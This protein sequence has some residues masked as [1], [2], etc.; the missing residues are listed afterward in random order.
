MSFLANLRIRPKL[1]I[2]MTPL[3]VMVVAATLYSSIQSK[4]IDTWYSDL[5]NRDVKALQ[6]LTAV[7]ARG[8]LFGLLLYKD[9]AEADAERMHVIEADLDRAYANYQAQVAEAERQNPALSQEIKLVVSLFDQAVADARPVR[10]ASLAGDN[11]KAMNLMRGRVDAELDRARIAIFRLVDEAQLS[12][13]RKSDELSEKTHRTILTTWIAL[14]LGLLASSIL[15]IVIV[16]KEVVSELLALHGSIGDLAGGRL[17]GVIPYQ[18]HASEIGE[19]SRA[20][21]TLQGVARE[22]NT[23]AWVKAQVAATVESLQPAKDFLEFS[24]SLLSRL[25]DAI[26]LLYGVVYVADKDRTRFSPA[27]SFA[28]QGQPDPE[29]FAL[30]EGLVGQAAFE[31]RTLVVTANADNAPR[32]S[33][34]VGQAEPHTLLFVPVVNQKKAEAVLELAPVSPLSERQ[35]ALL[36]A[37]LSSV[38]ANLEI[39]SGNME[40][41]G[42]LEQ[43]RMQAET[44]AASERQL[45]ARK[46][47]LESSNAALA[48]SEAELRRAKEVAEEATQV[49]SD[50]LARMSHEIRTPMNAVIGMS[51]LALRTD[52]NPR[53][54]DY[55]RKIQQ[56][57]QHLLGLIND[58]L[59]FSKIEAGKLSVENIDFDLEKMLEN[60]SNLTS[61][62]AAA[63]GLELILDIDPAVSMH[64][65]GDPL[66]LGQILINFCNNAVK[67]TE[68]GEIV[69]RIRV[70]EQ[71]E[72]GQLIHFAVSDTGIGLTE[73]QMGRLFQ[74]FEQADA[75][76]TRQYGG[77]GLGLAISKRLAELMGGEIGVTS[78]PGKGSTFWFT[79]RLG[80]TEG[81]TRRSV[82]HPDLRGRRVLVIDD[83]SQ[84][85]AVLSDM[86]TAMTLVVHEAPS[87]Q[88]GI[89]MVRRAAEARQPY[90]IV[91]LDWQMPGLDGIETGKRIRGLPGPAAAPHL[92]MVTA[93]GR[94]EV[95]KQAE[96]SGFESVLIKPVS[97]SM[98]FDASIRA[99]SAESETRAGLAEAQAGPSPEAA[100]IR[101]ARVLLVEDNEINREV[102]LGLLDGAHL[103]I[104]IAENGVAAVRMVG[105][106]EYDVVLMDMQMPVMDG[107]T[108]SRKIRSDA[109][110]S[111][112]PIIAMTASALVSDREKC[113]QAG[114]ND[115]I[116]K[117]ID[118]GQ[119]FAVLAR[120][121]KPREQEAA[122]SPAPA[123][124]AAR[125]FADGSLPEIEGVDVLE[126]LRRVA[127]NQRL[128]RDLLAKFA[129][130]QADSASQI[131]AALKSGDPK[132]AE[133]IAHSMKGVAGNLGISAIQSAAEKLEAAIRGGDAGVPALLR[134]TASLLAVQ[135]KAIQR[136][137]PPAAPA[138]PDGPGKAAFD[139][140]A[141][142]AGVARLRALL[143]ASDGDAGEAFLAL[144]GALAGAV[145][146]PQVEALRDA[147]ADFDF[148]GGLRKLG[149]IAKL[150]G[151]TEGRA[152]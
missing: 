89:E 13:D 100:R 40:T 75:S 106:H 56:S 119:L 58:I 31:Q 66:R 125:E 12:V 3:G 14:G 102:A 61:E 92:V 5:L 99:L 131:S 110:F 123:T 145:A 62:K 137:L 59:D 16:Q 111:E 69:V 52:L 70:Q 136:A 49:K 105:E 82:S 112:L 129:A 41:R 147:I 116:A 80:K 133:R 128:F 148:E 10:A 26:P 122:R 78:E 149:E 6:T 57:G 15:A 132:L 67:F 114:M 47:E 95:M 53:Q 108:A 63:K 118:P 64:L 2:A 98:L 79:A 77:T 94:E 65:R 121:V 150:C 141:V 20:L 135:V 117:P 35:Q 152:Q 27:G 4:L 7:R 48:A 38:A 17:D 51:H 1:L 60:V 39:L 36:D 18:E 46:E 71:D 88:E 9:I 124:P 68:R 29:G 8:N 86:L 45:T 96:A 21:H 55:V 97:P 115:H 74:A 87:G 85:R 101:G 24:R 54:R 90:E 151:V 83:N 143:E 140:Q 130:K 134:Q 73:E 33:A 146:K 144:E 126:G 43:T 139:L 22:R 19:M 107:L 25:S 44:L 42:L 28:L 142:S 76:T 93:Y 109:R 81:V 104:D 120:W 34:G 84:A 50:F 23:Q 32:V 113:L 127:G 138:H 103:T 91:F 72:A 30:G 11:V 37:L